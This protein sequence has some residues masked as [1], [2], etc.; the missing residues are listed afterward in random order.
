MK[1]SDGMSIIHKALKKAEGDQ[2]PVDPSA[3]D[4][5]AMAF[6]G[7]GG[8]GMGRGLLGGMPPLRLA[9]MVVL[10]AAVGFAVYRFF[11]A[12]QPAAQGVPTAVVPST[13]T[14]TPGEKAAEVPTRRPTHPDNENL[15]AGILE[16]VED[17]ET[18]FEAEQYPAALEK[19]EAAAKEE[20][21]MAM[22]WNN[23]G[24]TQRKIGNLEKAAESYEK[25]LSLDPKFAPAMNNLG[26]LKL[27]AG[28]RLAASLYFRKALAT[29]PTYAD[30]HFNLAVLMEEEGNWQSAVEAYKQFL[31]NTTIVDEAFLEKVKLRVEEI[32]P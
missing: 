13:L 7:G 32:A 11:F 24:L 26:M 23:I 5:D 18:F 28:D 9:L 3:A 27:A 12:A 1:E 8:G 22:L 16:L 17:G 19:F 25:A 10:I 2:H 29:D 15:P 20:P 31:T 6:G 4:V 30:A 14:G 21:E